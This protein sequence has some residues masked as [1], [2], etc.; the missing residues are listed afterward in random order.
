MEAKEAQEQTEKRWLAIIADPA[1]YPQWVCGWCQFAIGM[2]TRG[3]SQC[4]K[5]PVV[6]VFGCSC[7]DIPEFSAWERAGYEDTDAARKVYELLIAHGDQLIAAAKE[8]EDEYSGR[9]K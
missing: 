6:R 7:P 8:I 2:R 3:G 9:V 4:P 5:C 1:D